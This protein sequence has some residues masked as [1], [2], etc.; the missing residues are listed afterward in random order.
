MSPWQERN[1]VTTSVSWVSHIEDSKESLLNGQWDL[2]IVDEAHK[3]SAY[4]TDKKTLAYQLGQSLS[5]MT[6]HFS[7]MTATPH[8]GDP[9]NFCLFLSLLDKDVYGNVKSLE[10]AMERREAPFYLRRLKEA[11]VSFS[12]PDTG[13]VKA[14]FTEWI[15][16]NLPPPQAGR[17][18]WGVKED[19]ILAKGYEYIP[20]RRPKDSWSQKDHGRAA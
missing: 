5:Q 9:E 1:Q 2:I 7:L 15:D 11:L 13:I 20:H 10:D 17:C 6:D 4:S 12:D 14:L 3:I 8:K 16:P 19:E 18:I